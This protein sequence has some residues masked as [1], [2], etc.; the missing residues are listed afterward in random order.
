MR[1][2]LAR[3]VIDREEEVAEASASR[4]IALIV[5]VALV[6]VVAVLPAGVALALTSGVS[7]PLAAGLGGLVAV[8][9]GGKLAAALWGL[10]S[11]VLAHP[12]LRMGAASIE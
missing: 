2:G 1:Q 11:R 12:R 7:G 6:V 5:V 8:I 10:G 9:G 4:T 3:K